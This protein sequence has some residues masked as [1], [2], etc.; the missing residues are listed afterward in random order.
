MPITPNDIYPR[1]QGLPSVS[2][3]IM[4]AGLHGRLNF[5]TGQIGIP[6]DAM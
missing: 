2:C 5:T 4:R 1:L 6:E 3:L